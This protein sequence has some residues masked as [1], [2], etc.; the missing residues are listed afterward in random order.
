M[1][2]CMYMHQES[3]KISPPPEKKKEEKRLKLV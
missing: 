3:K 2:I 1:Y